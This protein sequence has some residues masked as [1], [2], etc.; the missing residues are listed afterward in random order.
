MSM[1]LN[2]MKEQEMAGGSGAARPP[3]RTAKTSYVPLIVV[4]ALFVVALLGLASYWNQQDKEL[5]KQLDAN[6]ELLVKRLDD[7]DSRMAKVQ[8]ELT[9]TQDRVGM[10]QRD[11]ERAQQLATQLKA[12]QE[13][14]VKKLSAEL[15]QK[16][17]TTEVATLKEATSAQIGT[18]SEH[19]GAVKSE[20]GTVKTEVGAVRQDVKE[21]REELDRTKKDL[22]NMNLVVDQQGKLIATNSEGLE[23]LRMKGERE[24][25]E[26]DIAKRE[27]SKQVGDIRLELR[28]ADAKK[29]NADIRILI[30]D[31]QVDKGKVFVNEPVHVRQGRQGLDY[32]VVINQVLKDQIRGYLSVPKNRA[33]AAS[34]PKS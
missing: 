5:R 20:V 16:A 29:Q 24:Y 4:S 9:V 17:S 3:A 13:K 14:N 8:S 22:A 32:E 21:T 7:S 28:K 33:L 1:D 30:N 12:E 34:G 10:T 27:K 19:V 25:F 26:F 18:V 11:L 15:S 6:H 31:T 2:K 23:T